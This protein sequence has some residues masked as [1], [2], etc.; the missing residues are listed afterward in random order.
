QRLQARSTTDDLGQRDAGSAHGVGRRTEDAPEAGL[1]R[2]ALI[3]TKRKH[4]SRTYKAVQVTK[5]G[6][7]ELIDRPIVEPAFGQV[8][9]RCEA[10]GVCAR[11]RLTGPARRPSRVARGDLSYGPS[12][13][14]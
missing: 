1:S 14:R 4:M 2:N 8:R 9:I 13:R 7:L 10:C 5:P 3:S 6:T 11:L 12:H